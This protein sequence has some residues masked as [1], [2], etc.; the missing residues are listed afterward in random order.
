MFWCS[1]VK[2]STSKKK[3]RY[4]DVL[5]AHLE[6]CDVSSSESELGEFSH[7]DSDRDEASRS[8]TVNR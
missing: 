8:V 5:Q 4:E 1:I 2:M 7:T 3:V 6:D